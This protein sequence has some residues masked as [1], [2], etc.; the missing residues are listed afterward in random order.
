M[1]RLGFVEIS[2][3]GSHKKLRHADGR[4]VI[5]PMHREVALGTLRSILRQARTTAEQLAEVLK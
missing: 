4:T 2:Q 3:K 5:V 1:K